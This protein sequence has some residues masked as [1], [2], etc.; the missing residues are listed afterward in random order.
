MGSTLAQLRTRV[1]EK[2]D[3][4][5]A[6]FWSDT[7]INNQLNEGYRFYWAFIIE[8]FEAYFAKT[9]LLDF[10]ANSAGEYIL[11]SDF[12]KMRLVEKIVGTQRTP[13]QY[14]ERYDGTISISLAQS[15]YNFPTYRF[16]GSK[17][18]FEP[19]PDYTLVGAVQLEY[20]R[21]LTD[22]SA[23]QDVDSEYPALA[24]DCMVL[25]AVLK[26]KAVE[27]MVAGGGVDA[28]PFIKDLA[29]TEQA[30]KELI[31]QKTIARVYVEQFGEQDNDNVS[32]WTI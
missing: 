13:L 19:A 21:K 8:A 27:E 14:F 5:T 29:T 11:P 7:L 28:D 4:D 12:F 25:R 9:S 22:L 16:R 17:I 26:C 24:E 30:L 32:V 10:D 1:R 6:A 15:T 23:S 3:E 18:V 31:E 2:V 20:I